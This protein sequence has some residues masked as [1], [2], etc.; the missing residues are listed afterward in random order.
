[1]KNDLSYIPQE[2]VKVGNRVRANKLSAEY[3]LTPGKEYEILGHYGIRYA[4]KNDDGM[5]TVCSYKCFAKPIR[6]GMF[7]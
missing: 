1:M 4:V 5:T 3:S 6:G 2:Q 7:R